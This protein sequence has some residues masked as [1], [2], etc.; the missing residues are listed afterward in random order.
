[1]LTLIPIEGI[2]TMNLW[3]RIIYTLHVTKRMAERHVSTVDVE[4]VIAGA[5]HTYEGPDR[6]GEPKWTARGFAG[7]QAL[8]VVYVETAEGVLEVLLVITVYTL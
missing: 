4:Q 8:E 7:G 2:I 6:F 1:V 5:D 3:R